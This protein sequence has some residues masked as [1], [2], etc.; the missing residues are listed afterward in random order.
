VN[1]LK[2]KH[3]DYHPG[4]RE[5]PCKK[6]GNII[7]TRVTHDGRRD[8]VAFV[9]GATSGIGM[10]VALR[11]A[12]SGVTVGV[13]GRNE[14]AA[15]GLVDQ[16]QQQGGK[17]TAL[18]ADVSRSEQV[19]SAV[20]ALISNFGRLDTVVS[21]AGI[22]LGGTV[23]E[24]SEQDCRLVIDVNL[25][26]TFHVAKHTIAHLLARGKG[27]FIAVSSDA[28]TMGAKGFAAYCASKHGVNGLIKCLALDY[29]PKG[30]RSNA[31]SPG[32]VETPMTDRLFSELSEAE[33]NFYRRSVPLGRFATPSDVANVI[34]FLSSDEGQYANGMIYALDGGSTAGYF[35]A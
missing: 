25:Q 22:A 3:V 10:A 8:E 32:F 11:L 23:E 5:R 16:I 18:L 12:A 7:M 31:V 35:A 9:T 17:A 21:C 2:E 27:S 6:I 33:R 19:A 30:I 28:G 34:A 13:V 14:K 26:G 4:A 29:G 15:H 1:D 20:A 24:M